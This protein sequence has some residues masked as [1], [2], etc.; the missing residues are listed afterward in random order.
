[1][2]LMYFSALHNNFPMCVGLE[3]IRRP[4]L[5]SIAN[6]YDDTTKISY[7]GFCN[8]DVKKRG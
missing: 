3:T 5:A 7:H 4:F 2:L 1:M 6:T 8:F